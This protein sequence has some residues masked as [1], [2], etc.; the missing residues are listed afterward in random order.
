[1]SGQD[2]G[3]ALADLRLA[4]CRPRGARSDVDDGQFRTGCLDQVRDGISVAGRHRSGAAD[5]FDDDGSVD[6]VDGT[7]PGKQST[8][9]VRGAFIEIG[10]IAST[11][12]AAKLHLTG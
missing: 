10:D 5:G 2:S 11:K 12:Q 9:A 6:D 1:M 7:G 8:D 3:A 4:A